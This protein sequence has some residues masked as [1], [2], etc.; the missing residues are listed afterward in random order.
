MKNLPSVLFDSLQY[1]GISKPILGNEKWMHSDYQQAETFLKS[2]TGSR[3]TFNSYRREVERL[4][5]WAWHI[6]KKSIVDIKRTDLEE[7]IQFCQ[8]PPQTWIGVNKVPRFIVNNGLRISNPEWRPFVVTIPKANHRKGEQPDVKDYELSGDTIK[9][10]FAILS[11]LYNY[12]LQ[13]EYAFMNP[14]ALLRQKSKFIRKKQGI[15]KIRR[16]TELQWEYLINTATE[17]ANQNS[18]HERTLFIISILYGMYLRISELAATDRWT[19]CMNHFER[20]YEGNWWFTT[21]GKGNK[22]R[23]VAVS[24]AMLNALKRWRQHLNL[25][26]LPSLVDKTVLIPKTKGK[27]PMSSINHI[28]RIV[29]ACFDRAIARLTNDHFTE[30]AEALTVATVHWLRHTGISDDVKRRP[31]EHVRDDAGH[32]SSMTTDK[33]VDVELRERHLSAKNKPISGIV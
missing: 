11:S 25:P 24:D 13:E 5:Q 6:Q 23:K 31:R 4:L 22:E 27:G 26:P 19:P 1:I 18:I 15:T 9:E 20:D 29:Q 16:L 32:T 10:I 12:L 30:E 8:N 28:R 3:G 17:M 2:Y 21:V 33:Y 14:V 7:Y